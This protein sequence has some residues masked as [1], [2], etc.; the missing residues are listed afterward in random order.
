MSTPAIRVENIGKKYRLGL[1]HAGSLGELAN[2]WTRRLR[3]L[4]PVQAPVEDGG[5]VGDAV[6]AAAADSFWALRDVSFEVQPGEVVGIIG[7]NGAG[8]S[9]LL[10]VLARI[11]VP[12]TGRAE[13]DGRVGSLLEVG[14]GFHPELTGRENI[15]M[16][17]ALLGMSRSEVVRKIDEIVDFSGVEAFL[18]TPVKRYSSGMKVRLGFA[19]AAHLEPE[20]LIIDEVLSVGDAEFRKK[21][22]GKMQGVARQGRTI[23]F[24]SHNMAAVQ[25]LCDRILNFQNGQLIFD[26]DSDEAVRNYMHQLC[27]QGGRVDLDHPQVQRSGSGGARIVRVEM[28]DDDDRPTEVL[29]FGG[30]LRLRVTVRST[31]PRRAVTLALGLYTATGF[32]LSQVSSDA[33][34]GMTYDVAPGAPV[35]VEATLPHSRLGPELYRLNLGLMDATT[36]ERLD[37]VEDVLS[38][39]VPDTDVYGTGR[40]VPRGSVVVMPFEWRQMTDPESDLPDPEASDVPPTRPALVAADGGTR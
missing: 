40:R 32:C 30:R 9:T 31:G 8:K 13:I 2:R 34:A 12:T 39:E 28:L 26:G 29:P 5:H 14:T 33:M 24:V 37:H 7:R 17:A 38:F 20:V 35:V 25:N 10:K 3:G 18:D 4:P 27:A 16:N 22:L 11:T 19:V 36:R 23:L 21:C 6:K 1:T 15:F